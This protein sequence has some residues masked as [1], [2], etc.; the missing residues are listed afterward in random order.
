MFGPGWLS[1]LKAPKRCSRTGGEIVGLIQVEQ[2]RV[3]LVCSQTE[4]QCVDA[5]SAQSRAC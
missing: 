3:V 1:G 4:V 5:G 2:V